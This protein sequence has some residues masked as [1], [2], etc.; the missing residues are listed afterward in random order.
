MSDKILDKKDWWEYPRWLA[1]VT[2]WV[3][4][5]LIF[6]LLESDGTNFFEI[7]L[8]EFINVIFYIILIYVNLY[9]LI[10]RFLTEKLFWLYGI[11]LLALVVIVT[12]AKIVI[13]YIRFYN[14]PDIQTSL[15]IEQQWLFIFNFIIVGGST[16]FKIIS[17]WAK[18]QRERKE[19]ERQTMQSELN[20]LRSQ[21]N[22]HFLFNTLN[23]LYALTLKK[24]D[25]APETVLKL[26]EIMRYML[27]ECNERR[28]PL[29]KEITYM[30]NYLELE[31]LRHGDGVNI[32]FNIFG[33]VNNKVIA[34]LLL[35]PF[36]E[37]A[38]KHGV[39]NQIKKGY[40]K[41]NMTLDNQY[42]LFDI[43]NSKPTGVVRKSSDRSG[44]IGL[45][46]VQR[47]LNLLYPRKYDLE[48]TNSIEEYKVFLKLVLD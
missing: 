3:S 20:F 22:P 7:L 21:I 32:E 48:I 43:S 16:I 39:K 41:I 2:F 46:N 23:S 44:G 37:N 15:L 45:V 30:K 26:S 12:P 34:P 8:N 13:F 10:P 24:S 5:W 14:S 1:H 27:Y 4:I 9:Y 11:L 29:E 6:T 36:L 33:E 40:V 28:V 31:K 47:R 19:L 18:H 38:F 42:L 25:K 17:D 35:I